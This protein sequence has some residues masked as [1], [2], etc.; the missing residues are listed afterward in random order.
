[1]RVWGYPLVLHQPPSVRVYS[2]HVNVINVIDVRNEFDV[3]DV[4]GWDSE[5]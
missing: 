4:R 2:P 3:I 1:M 5:R